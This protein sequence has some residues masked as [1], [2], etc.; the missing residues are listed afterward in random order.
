MRTVGEVNT[1]Y[2]DGNYASNRA[3]AILSNLEESI[4]DSCI[5]ETSDDSTFKT[6]ILSPN[7]TVDNLTTVYGSGENLTFDLK[8]T[9]AYQSPMEISYKCL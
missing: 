9:A 3:G 6:R 5:F 4:A 8:T 1:S 7:L 2:F